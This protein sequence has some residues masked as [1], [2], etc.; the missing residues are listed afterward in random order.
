MSRWRERGRR[1]YND[2][3]H[4]MRKLLA[5]QTVDIYILVTDFDDD[6]VWKEAEA[7]KQLCSFAFYFGVVPPVAG[8][9]GTN[10]YPAAASRGSVSAAST[11]VSTSKPGLARRMLGDKVVDGACSGDIFAVVVVA[12]GKKVAPAI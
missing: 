12:S 3:K 10:N 9:D 5:K 7:S 4:Q 2:Q 11:V 6:M 1:V 8:G